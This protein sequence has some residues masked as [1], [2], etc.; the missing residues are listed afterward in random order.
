MC[1][2]RPTTSPYFPSP[3][4]GLLDVVFAE[5]PQNVSTS[6]RVVIGDTS[7]IPSPSCILSCLV[8]RLSGTTPVFWTDWRLC[9]GRSWRAG[10]REW[11]EAGVSDDECNVIW[12]A[13][14]GYVRYPELEDDVIYRNGETQTD[15]EIRSCLQVSFLLKDTSQISK[16]FAFKF[17]QLLDSTRY[18]K[19][20]HFPHNNVV[21]VVNLLRKLWTFI[22]F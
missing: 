12:I 11:R 14:H 18:C 6:H 17:I 8:W 9:V 21:L 7:S 16:H 10:G 3:D 1:H 22:Q 15:S 20:S 2:C 4:Q 13:V 19:I 5:N